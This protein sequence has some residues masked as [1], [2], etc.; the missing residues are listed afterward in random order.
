MRSR[1]VGAAATL[2]VALGLCGC[3][4][5]GPQKG[6]VSGA[7]AYDGKP[8]E[9]GAIT[10]IPADG[11]SPTAGAAIKGGKYAA[12]VPVGNMKVSIS[13]SKVIGTKKLYDTPDSPVRQITAEALPAKYNE[14][15]ELRYEVKAGPNVKDFDLAK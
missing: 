7:V 13:A 8:V 6:E 4:G 14:K 1:I 15:T 9:D 2:A 5:G 12:T 10:F 3:G 11:K